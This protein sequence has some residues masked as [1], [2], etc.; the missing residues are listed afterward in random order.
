MK[1]LVAVVA[2]LF[3][4]QALAIDL[5]QPGAMQKLSRDNPAHYAK[6]EK[7]LS[8]AP[9]RPYASMARWIRTEF[10]ATDVDASHLLRTSYP[11]QARLSFVLDG[12][13]YSK[14]IRIDA[15][16]RAIPAK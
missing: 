13:P 10:N 6:V 9:H 16:A 14:V 3:A 4:A 7:I 1:P 8:E 12:Q 2:L 15:P 11:A 5:D